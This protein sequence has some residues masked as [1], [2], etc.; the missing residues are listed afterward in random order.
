MINTM[1][2]TNDQECL[3]QLKTRCRELCNQ[4]KLRQI[5]LH[6]A[7]QVIAYETNLSD[8]QQ[9]ILYLL[10]V[11]LSDA[12]A[13]GQVCLPLSNKSLPGNSL[14]GQNVSASDNVLRKILPELTVF[15]PKGIEADQ[16]LMDCASVYCYRSVQDFDSNWEYQPLILDRRYSQSRLYLARYYFYEMTVYQSIQQ[17]LSSVQSCLPS[18]S[19]TS[20]S[21]SETD[22]SLSATLQ[23]LFP[24]SHAQDGQQTIDWQNIAAATACL[25]PFTVITGGPGT[26]K[27]TTVTRLLSALLS[28]QPDLSIAL[29]A[30]TGK[31]AARM[32]ESIRGA[33]QRVAQRDNA[34]GD[35]SSNQGLPFAD[36]IPDTSFTLHRLLG[37]S[38]RGFRYHQGHPL[39]YDCVVVDE[40]SMIDLPMMSHLMQ[41][42]SLNTRL[43]LLGD[44][45][46]LA[47]VEAGSVLAD[48]CDAGQE[49]GPAP[50]FAQQL[51][52]LTGQ[53][54]DAYIEPPCSQMQNAL[55]QLRVSHRFD[56]N[57]GI[58]QL[59]AAVNAGD[60]NKALTCFNDFDDIELLW[61]QDTS[62]SDLAR[63]WQP[64]VLKGYRHYCKAVQGKTAESPATQETMSQRNKIAAI[65]NAFN[66]FQVLLATRQGLTGVEEVNQRIEQLLRPLL[67]PQR[68]YSG[69]MYPGRAIMITRNDY[70]LGLFNGD[71]GILVEVETGA[72][73]EAGI[74]AEDRREA[75]SQTK[76][77]VAFQSLDE[78]QG[79]IR[80]LMPN[81]LPEHETAFA[82]TVHKS[83]GS[84]FRDVFLMLPQQWQSVVTRELI[85]TAITRAKKR[86]S[87]LT[88]MHSLQVGVTTVVQRASGLRDR[89]WKNKEG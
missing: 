8:Q 14:T 30:P 27:T 29:A 59:A 38:P 16:V 85:Y 68:R 63:S 34:N 23:Q 19:L 41:A 60:V 67:D 21:I 54:L 70:D 78:E 37:W 12:L 24:Q 15:W 46:Q 2:A 36:S 56:A 50:E 52:Q 49:H 9:I 84:E 86:F 42:L 1:P 4:H 18:A 89:L 79:N 83:Q 73:V 43:I 5:D 61:H 48:L 65:L 57:S 44:R 28:Q 72:E 3:A 53:N 87:L 10:V 81:R 6:M 64:Q 88:S 11:L 40:A 32:T 7:Q 47:S 45:D 66:D 35:N 77:K 71:I 39:P 76:L 55:A 58:G 20:E 69:A 75:A 25:Q 13:K 31:A 74:E 80:L 22:H 62:A 26:G 51:S 17:R 82:M 33:K